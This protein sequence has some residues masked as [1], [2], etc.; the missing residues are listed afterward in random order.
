MASLESI[1]KNLDMSA[2]ALP[3]NKLD[4]C[5]YFYSLLEHEENRDHFRW[6]LSA[7]L[8]ACYSHLEI[9]AKSLFHAFQDPETGETYQD[10]DALTILGKYVSASQNKKKPEY[11]KT[12]G[13]LALTEKLYEI[14]NK[15]THHYAL[16]IMRLGESPNCRFQIGHMSGEGVDALIFCEEILSLFE[17]IESELKYG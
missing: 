13:L 14:R 6:L 3:D 2:I 16:S 9:T 15:N 8:G 4:E 17:Q 12:K 5:K 10:D 11:V 7:F 1:L